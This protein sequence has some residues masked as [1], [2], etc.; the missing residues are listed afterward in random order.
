MLKRLSSMTGLVVALCLAGA[1]PAFAASSTASSAS[2][3]VTTSVGSISGSFQR[4][5]ASSSNNDVADGDYKVIEMAEVAQQP[6]MVRMKLQ[7]VASAGDD[8]EFFLVLPREAVERG[9]VAV[10]GVVTARSRDYGYEFA[11]QEERQPF[12]LVLADEWYK[13]LQSRAVSL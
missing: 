8:G 13:E 3:S 5:S 10:G 12:F 4:S 6:G 1:A 11:T 7:A 2:D 9:R